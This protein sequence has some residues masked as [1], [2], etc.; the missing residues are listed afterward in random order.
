MTKVSL[1]ELLE[2]LEE[3]EKGGTESSLPSFEKDAKI[4]RSVTDFIKEFEIKLGNDRIPAYKIY[5]D[6]KA[7]ER[8]QSTKLSKIEFF[9]QFNKFFKVKRGNRGR[10]YLLD[11]ES[12]DMS[13]NSLTKAKNYDTIYQ[14]NVSRKKSDKKTKK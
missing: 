7:W 5:Y 14:G 13:E 6:Y 4:P 9:R 11:A 8:F 12:F 2:K 3:L 1:D 10:Y